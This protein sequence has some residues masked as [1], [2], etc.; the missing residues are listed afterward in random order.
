MVI[1]FAVSILMFNL[2]CAK[3]T[4]AT[5]DVGDAHDNGMKP[6]DAAMTMMIVEMMRMMMKI[7]W[8][9]STWTLSHVSM[10]PE[11]NA[12]QICCRIW[13]RMTLRN[14]SRSKCSCIFSMIAM[15]NR[16]PRLLT[17]LYVGS[18]QC[19]QRQISL[20]GRY[21]PN[22]ARSLSH[23]ILRVALRTLFRL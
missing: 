23:H 14:W 18:L 6:P 12:N 2:S 16:Q 15:Q 9:K 19:L 4:T 13:R 11:R 1:F 17:T 8:Q 3:Y 22:L 5:A 10:K 21:F 7:G 20:I